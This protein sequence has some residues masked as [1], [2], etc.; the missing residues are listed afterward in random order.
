MNYLLCKISDRKEKQKFRR[1]LAIDDEIYA[2]PNL[3]NEVPYQ[4]TYT[5]EEDEWF[6][7]E[8]FT[9]EGYCIDLLKEKFD[10]T[11]YTLAYT[12]NPGKISYLC[13]YQNNNTYC[14]QRVMP[15][16]MIKGKRFIGLGDEISIK[17]VEHGI[18]L[19]TVPDA[20]FIT[21]S[22]RLY[23]RKL[24]TITSI[25]SGI[26]EIYRE[27]TNDEV[28]HFFAEDFVTLSEN[29]G[30]DNVG[31][32]NRKRLAWVSD[33]LKNLKPE[34]KTE[35]F[36]YIHD[37]KPQL[38]YTNRKFTIGSEDDLKNLAFGIDQRFYT[39]PVTKE[40]RVANSVLNL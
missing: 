27:A 35:I 15:S 37:Y 39:T 30:V 20:V 6:V 25:F 18:T 7:L 40:P 17:S 32:A 31:K 1:M 10:S 8:N 13:A 19:Q 21:E 23:F 3:E 28:T 38:P 16:S 36:D 14:F 4:A 34:Q 29:F 2:I 24:E 5:L 12:D 33:K 11:K 22:N 26:Q 9:N